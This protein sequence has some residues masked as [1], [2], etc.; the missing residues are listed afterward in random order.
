MTTVV[1]I[2]GVHILPEFI[3]RIR[4]RDLY[5]PEHVAH[6]KNSAGEQ[7]QLD[8]QQHQQQRQQQQKQQQQQQRQQQ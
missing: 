7:Q 4:M 2:E 3:C 1:N 6:L 8:P 5:T